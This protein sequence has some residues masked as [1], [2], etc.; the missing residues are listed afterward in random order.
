MENLGGLLLSRKAGE[1]IMIGNDIEITVV[2]ISE[3]R[4]KL[5][6]RA[7]KD[8]EIYRSEIWVRMQEEGGQDDEGSNNCEHINVFHDGGK[9]MNNSKFKFRVW[10]KQEKHMHYMP[11][12]ELHEELFLRADGVLCDVDSGSKYPD[13]R[14]VDDRYE[15]SFSTGLYDCEGK[16][17]WEGDIIEKGYHGKTESPYQEV[18]FDTDIGSCGCC[19]SEFKGS[20]FAL[21]NDKWRIVGNRFENPELLEIKE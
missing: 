16:E 8:V 20:G 3:K 21:P 6:L 11:A 1:S 12:A 4:V 13:P 9:A 2:L 18:V 15:V 14:P 17:I 19:F 5:A 7:P 10:D